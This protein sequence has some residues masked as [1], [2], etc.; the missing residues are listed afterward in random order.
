[1]GPLPPN[2]ATQSALAPAS[3]SCNM[4]FIPFIVASQT[5]LDRYKGNKMLKE[6]IY[7][8]ATNSFVMQH[9]TTSKI[10]DHYVIANS[11]T[12]MLGLNVFCQSI[13]TSLKKNLQ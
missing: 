2:P 1:M 13:N 9:V 8:T 11:N 6:N 12:R 7:N 4:K 10:I 5:G 3:G